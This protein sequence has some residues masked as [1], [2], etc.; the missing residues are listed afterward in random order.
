MN[1][2]QWSDKTG[3]NRTNIS[4]RIKRGLSGEKLFAPVK[5]K[6]VCH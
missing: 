6:G 5:G 1:I 3:I 2:S 4:M